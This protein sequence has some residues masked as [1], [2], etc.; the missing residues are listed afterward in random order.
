MIEDLSKFSKERKKNVQ[1][2]YNNIGKNE[3][4]SKAVAIGANFSGCPCIVVC[5]WI[6]EIEGWSEELLNSAN[7]LIKF[8]CYTE[9]L[10]APSGFPTIE[11]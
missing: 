8:Y 5:C 10:N 6:A 2:W 9:I 3:G 7:T 11:K 4:P 1:N